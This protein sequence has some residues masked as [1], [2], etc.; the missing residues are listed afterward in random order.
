MDELSPCST[1]VSSPSFDHIAPSK[2]PDSTVSAR[3]P[4]AEHTAAPE[5]D[6]TRTLHDSMVT[7]SPSSGSLVE[8]DK[9]H[10]TKTDHDRHGVPHSPPQ[11]NTND[12]RQRMA[13]LAIDAKSGHDTSRMP[14][15]LSLERRTRTTPVTPSNDLFKRGWSFETAIRNNAE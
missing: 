6:F 5:S 13:R 9:Q 10:H 14:F 8:N 4:R 7:R 2:T 3:E 12:L 15:A 11:F 1:R